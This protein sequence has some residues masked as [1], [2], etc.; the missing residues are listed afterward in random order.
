M[1]G[2]NR[3]PDVRQVRGV[4]VAVLDAEPAELLLDEAARRPVDRRR[5][6]QVRALRQQRHVDHRHGAHPGGGRHAVDPVLELGDVLLERAD[7]GVAD[8]RVDEPVGPAREPVGARLRVVEREGRGLV[9]RR[10]GAAEGVL[11]HARVHELRVE[12]ELLGVHQMAA[13]LT[14]D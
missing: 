1:F 6:D 13:R 4:H 9:D 14:T 8:A 7:R 2:P 10:H 11:R 5:A 12:A 3:R